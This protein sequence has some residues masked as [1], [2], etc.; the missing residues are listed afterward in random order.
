[1]KPLCKITSSTFVVVV[2]EHQWKSR[3]KAIRTSTQKLPQPSTVSNHIPAQQKTFKRIGTRI[4][5]KQCGATRLPRELLKSLFGRQF[6]H[7][8]SRCYLVQKRLSWILNRFR[9]MWPRGLEIR[10]AKKKCVTSVWFRTTSRRSTV[11][12]M[13][14]HLL[15]KHWESHERRDYSTVMRTCR[16]EVI[17]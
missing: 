10:K 12:L 6:Y 15:L 8:P 3:V 14:N 9:S 5:I 4:H 13:I 16:A 11:L 2:I 7:T 1:M 17:M